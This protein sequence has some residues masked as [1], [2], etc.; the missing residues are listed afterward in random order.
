MDSGD[1][2]ESIQLINNN[3]NCHDNKQNNNTNNLNEEVKINI[4]DLKKDNNN[5]D[6]DDDD[7]END[8]ME[9]LYKEFQ[10]RQHQ[11]S[12]R[13]TGTSTDFIELIWSNL[14]YSIVK[15]S[16]SMKWSKLKMERKQQQIDILKNLNGKFESNKLTAIMG[17]SGAGKTTLMECLAGRRQLGLTGKIMVNKF[18]I[19]SKIKIAYNSQNETLL[20]TLTV[21]E[22]LLFAS[23]ICNLEQNN[24]DMNYFYD[25]NSN[26]QDNQPDE[27]FKGSKEV[28]EYMQLKKD[29]KIKSLHQLMVENLMK[30]LGLD[31]CADVRISNCSGGQLRRVSIALE[32]ITSPSILLLDE[33]TSGLDSVSC[34]SCIS[35][36]KNLSKQAR[37]L[38]I[39]ASIHQP[40]AKLLSY[41]DHLYMI[42]YSG[43]CIYNG[44]PAKLVEHML[45]FDY[46]C[47]QYHNPADFI[48]EIANGDHGYE[49][50]NKLD[51]A[52]K[53][54]DNRFCLKKRSNYFS[55]SVKLTKILRKSHVHKKKYQF[56]LFKS[57]LG[58]SLKVT[59]R[60]PIVSY[61]RLVA[62]LLILV[63][64]SFLYMDNQVGL[65]SGCFEFP[66]YETIIDQIKPQKILS[67]SALG[68][69][70]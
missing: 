11:G 33:P 53:D 39:A 62:T 57:L 17:P 21:K 6:D 12:I 5:D 69:L 28:V 40:T 50:I 54:Q 20:K 56:T 25:Y 42:S 27:E 46:P 16:Y 67:P 44:P 38:I 35:L 22:T 49:I 15:T 47:P 7:E 66:S 8:E 19:N 59:A 70:H 61:L 24:F 55:G 23:K 4:K 29:G 64:I 13:S 3:F 43:Q 10:N 36:L 41:F 51:Q 32:L 2:T 65:V 52:V 31:Q 60:E 68:I 34:L 30:N 37:P 14:T 9:N 58:R 26:F 48:T 1:E 63:L 18:G 45:A